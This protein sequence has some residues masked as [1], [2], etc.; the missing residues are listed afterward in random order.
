M[1]A[2]WSVLPAP[3]MNLMAATPPSER[4]K[5]AS[6]YPALNF[7]VIVVG[8]GPGGIPAAIRAAQAGAKVALVE[9]DLAVGGAPVDM[10]V[11]TLFGQPSV[12]LSKALE[13]ELLRDHG[14]Y[15]RTSLGAK[16]KGW[17]FFSA[18]GICALAEPEYPQKKRI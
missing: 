14:L 4:R 5:S 1:R 17:R 6:F 7:D 2:F 11:T 16:P 15:T 9:E 3:G 13:Q 10:Y 8:A 12:G 18:F